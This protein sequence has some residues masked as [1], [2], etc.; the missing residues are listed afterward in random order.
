MCLRNNVGR[1]DNSRGLRTFALGK[2]R[3]ALNRAGCVAALCCALAGC[4]ST[5]WVA[6]RQTPGDSLTSRLHFWGHEE[7]QPTERTMLLLRRYDLASELK[8]DPCELL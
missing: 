8:G 6:M 5:N 2:F 4:A 3:Y 1:R 7:P